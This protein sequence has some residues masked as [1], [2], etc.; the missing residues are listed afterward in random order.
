MVGVH[1]ELVVYGV[2]EGCHAKARA[3]PAQFEVADE[4]LDK[5][6]LLL[7]VGCSHAARGVQE[8]VDVCW[9]GTAT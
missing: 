4:V 5:V 7:E 6:Q 8:E 9:F 3:V 1:P 2:A